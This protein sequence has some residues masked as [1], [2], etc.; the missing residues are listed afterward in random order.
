MFLHSN[1][2]NYKVRPVWPERFSRLIFATTRKKCGT[3]RVKPP[4]IKIAVKVKV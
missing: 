2:K 3:E 4:N 1:V